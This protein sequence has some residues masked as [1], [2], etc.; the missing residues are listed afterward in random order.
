MFV[1]KIVQNQKILLQVSTCCLAYSGLKVPGQKCLHDVAEL[2]P[3]K[4]VFIFAYA[5]RKVQISCTFVFA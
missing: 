5:K 1:A 3:I 4:S 2:R